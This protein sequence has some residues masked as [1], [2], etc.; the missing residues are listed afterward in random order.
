MSELPA[1]SVL[2]LDRQSW[3]L[4]AVI[5]DPG[6]RNAMSDRLANDL[7]AVLD[8]TENDRTLR[9]IVLRGANGVFCAGADLAGAAEALKAEPATRDADPIWIQNRRGGSLFARLNAHPQ[10]VIAVVEGP[11]MG[12]GV[13]LVC[14]A[15]VVLAGPGARFALSETRLGLVPAQIAPFVAARV[16]LSA[17]RRLALTGA[18]LDA[19]QALALGLVDQALDTREALEGALD[20]VLA[21]IGQCAP[22]ANAATKRLLLSA[23]GADLATF[24]GEAADAFTAA[25]RGPEG[26]EGLAAFAV[27]R[28]PKWAADA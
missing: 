7:E 1:T 27:K 13:G 16:G 22:G 2:R 10:A 12:G 21:D 4:F 23:A 17:A 5:D 11:A 6:T 14:C 26:R 9:A 25:L 19:R 20:A 24:A 15:D 18:R 28:A 8:A 3:K